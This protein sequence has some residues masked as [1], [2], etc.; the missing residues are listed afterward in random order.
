MGEINL[1][2]ERKKIL[3][4]IGDKICLKRKKRRKKFKSISKTL[5]I[6]IDHLSLIEDGDT[7]KFPKHVPVMGFI[8]AYAK[9]LEVDIDDELDRIE[10]LNSNANNSRDSMRG[11]GNF[12]NKFIYFLISFALIII[13]LFFFDL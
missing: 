11:K 1:E 8:R 13:I 9:F 12:P 10:I 2:N 4:E 5:N 7:Q 3:C 6:S